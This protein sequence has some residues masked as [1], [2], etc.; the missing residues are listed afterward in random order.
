MMAC[1]CVYCDYCRGSGHIWVNYDHLG[2]VIEDSGIDDLSDL[3][4]CPQC[5]GSA[6]VETCDECCEAE[7][8]DVGFGDAE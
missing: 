2:R 3:M 4:E 8:H 1:T 7:M 5:D 6:I